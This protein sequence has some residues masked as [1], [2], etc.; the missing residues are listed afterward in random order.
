MSVR[1]SFCYPMYASERYSPARLFEAAKAIGYEAV[2]FWGR[3]QFGDYNEIFGEAA[4]AGL[5][6]ASMIGHNSLGDGM[7]NVANHERIYGEI[8][9]SVEIA[10]RYSIPG[11]ICFSGNRTTGQG[12]LDGMRVCAQ[13]LRKVASITEQAKVNLNV[14]LLNSRIDHPGYQ[15]DRPDWGYALCEMVA[16]PYVKLLYDIY[17]MQIMTGDVI[18]SLTSDIEYLG[19]IHTAGNPGRGPL[20]DSQ[21]LNYRGICK[22]IDEAGYQ[23]FV[24]HEFKPT[25]DPVA[26]LREAY[27]ICSVGGSEE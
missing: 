25:G 14:E 4:G 9:E 11:L 20:D 22:A 17:H 15:C 8:S 21:E 1:Q 26:A 24:G 3:D 13:I 10:S 7:N 19:H 12:D 27:E 6:I 2:E 16:S 23:G 18:R 5:K